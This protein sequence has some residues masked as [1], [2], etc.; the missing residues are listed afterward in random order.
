MGFNSGFKGLI[1]V[2]CSENVPKNK[3]NMEAIRSCE[4]S[5][6]MHPMTGR[7]IPKT[8]M[9]KISLLLNTNGQI[10]SKRNQRS[11][12]GRYCILGSTS[13]ELTSLIKQ[14]NLLVST[15]QN[16]QNTNK[17]TKTQDQVFLCVTSIL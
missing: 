15:S 7:H 10:K 14:Q 13:S 9:L 12:K 4:T 8:I 16:K 3:I 1:C 11:W 17:Q 6:T 5:G 2:D